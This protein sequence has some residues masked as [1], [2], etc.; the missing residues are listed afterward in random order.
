MSWSSSL[1]ALTP[2]RGAMI[3]VRAVPGRNTSGAAARRSSEARR[4]RMQRASLRS[5]SQVLEFWQRFPRLGLNCPPLEPHQLR[6]FPAHVAGRHPRDQKTLIA[7]EDP[8]AEQV[9][10]GENPGRPEPPPEHVGALAPLEHLAGGQIRIDLD[11]S[12]VLVQRI[13]R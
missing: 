8:K 6:I 11:A 5:A 3:H 1:G 12:P 4:M 10:V 9:S 13:A 2:S 7:V